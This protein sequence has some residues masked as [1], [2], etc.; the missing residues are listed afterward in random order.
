MMVYVVADI[1]G[2]VK[3]VRATALAVL[4]RDALLRLFEVR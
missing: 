2:V 1:E 4:E 3:G